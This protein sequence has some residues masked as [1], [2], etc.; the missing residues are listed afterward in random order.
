MSEERKYLLSWQNKVSSLRKCS[1]DG[2]GHKRIAR[3]LQVN[4]TL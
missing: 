4:K 3:L 1:V 2:S